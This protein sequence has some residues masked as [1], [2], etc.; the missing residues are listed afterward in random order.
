MKLPNDC[1]LGVGQISDPTIK[2]PADFSGQRW[3]SKI[4]AKDPK[5]NKTH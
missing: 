1:I 4:L 2:A 3:D 5:K